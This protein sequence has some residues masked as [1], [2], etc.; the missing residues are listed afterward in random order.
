MLW[1][2]AMVLLALWVLGL[3]GSYAM[4]GLIHIFLVAAVVM[5]LARLIT[6]RKPV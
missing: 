4:G 3:V 6:G 1:T 2:I 5:M